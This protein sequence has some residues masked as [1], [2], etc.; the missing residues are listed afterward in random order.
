MLITLI[1]VI[2]QVWAYYIITSYILN[3]CSFINNTSIK[4][5]KILVSSFKDCCRG[6]TLGI[7]Q[8]LTPGDRLSLLRSSHI[9]KSSTALLKTMCRKQVMTIHLGNKADKSNKADG[10]SQCDSAESLANN[11]DV[12]CCFQEQ[13]RFSKFPRLLNTSKAM[14]NDGGNLAGSGKCTIL[15]SYFPK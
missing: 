2:S 11:R 5:K 9:R 6:E 1:V 8:M 4:Q 10:R 7:V 3:R 12:K 13:G 14:A 15:Y